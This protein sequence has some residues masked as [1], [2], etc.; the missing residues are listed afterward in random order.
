MSE[1]LNISSVWQS[2]NITYCIPI[3]NDCYTVH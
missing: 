3:E 1:L 2:Y